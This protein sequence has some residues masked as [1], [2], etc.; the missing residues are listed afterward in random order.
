[1]NGHNPK[2]GIANSLRRLFPRSE[3]TFPLGPASGGLGNQ[4]FQL[5]GTY[6]LAKRYGQRPLFPKNWAYRPYFSVPRSFFASRL[7]TSRCASAIPLADGIPVELKIYMQDLRL[8]DG[9]EAEIRALLAPSEYA[10][11]EALAR[12][13]VLSQLR[14]KTSVHVRRGDFLNYRQRTLPLTYYDQALDEIFAANHRTQIVLFSD[15]PAW[16]RKNVSFAKTA[17]VVEGNPDWLDLVLMS[18]CDHHVCANSTFSWWGAFLSSN[19]RPTVPWLP[20]ALPD[21]LRAIHPPRW[22]EIELSEPTRGGRHE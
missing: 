17:I 11:D 19:Q 14:S 6:A 20:G 9:R 2:K 1:M 10:R 22:R 7:K 4:L 16:C 18:L 21:A 13:P 5:A 12:L 3:L 15:D 8:W